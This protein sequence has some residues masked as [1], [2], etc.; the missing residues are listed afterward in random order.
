MARSG[1]RWK[2][3]APPREWF[4]VLG[5]A[6]PVRRSGELVCL[7]AFSAYPLDDWFHFLVPLV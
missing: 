5:L 6:V 7:A 1:S 2:K 4:D 3:S